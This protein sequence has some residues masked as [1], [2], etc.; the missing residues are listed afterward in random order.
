L[1]GNLEQANTFRQ[2]SYEYMLAM[3]GQPERWQRNQFY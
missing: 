1:R 3:S 2:A